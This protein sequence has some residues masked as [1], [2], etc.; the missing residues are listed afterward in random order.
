MLPKKITVTDNL[1]IR[2]VFKLKIY[3]QKCIENPMI[4]LYCEERLNGILLR[5]DPILEDRLTVSLLF[6]IKYHRDY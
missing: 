3:V 1:V 5:N 2:S 6:R 4:N